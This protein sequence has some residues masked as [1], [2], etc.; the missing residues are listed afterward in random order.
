MTLRFDPP[1]P[2]ASMAVR[3]PPIVRDQL[4][5]GLDVWSVARSSTEVVT[6]LVAYTT[7]QFH[8]S[9]VTKN[10]FVKSCLSH[11]Q[12]LKL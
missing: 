1:R 9:F 11:C 12:G 5:N 10:K 7:V 3:F 4:P 2:G 6:M 8:A